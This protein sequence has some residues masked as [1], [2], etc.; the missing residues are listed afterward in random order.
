MQ[1]M[2]R[3]GMTYGIVHM[4]QRNNMANETVVWMSKSNKNCD[5]VIAVHISSMTCEIVEIVMSD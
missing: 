5:V 4:I 3:K 1:V 2:L